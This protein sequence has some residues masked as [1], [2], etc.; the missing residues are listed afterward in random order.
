MSS[1]FQQVITDVERHL[2]IDSLELNEQNLSTNSS[3]T[4]GIKKST[5]Q[6]GLQQGIDL[7]EVNNGDFSFV[8]V[9]TRGMG[10]WRGAYLLSL[11]HI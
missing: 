8:V 9:P 11:I 10:I 4:W 1:T 2:W 3:S 7:I 6:A 5:L